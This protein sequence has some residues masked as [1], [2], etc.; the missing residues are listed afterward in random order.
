MATQLILRSDPWDWSPALV[1]D[2]FPPAGALPLDPAKLIPLIRLF[3]PFTPAT[4]LV[5]HVDAD[6]DRALGLSQT[7]DQPPALRSFSLCGL[8]VQRWGLLSSIY[9]DPGFRTHAPLS[10]WTAH[11]RAHN[12]IAA[13]EE[14]YSIPIEPRH[15]RADSR[16][17]HGEHSLPR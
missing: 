12:S 3:D 7:A 8:H 10:I 2:A 6:C 5:G 13:A 14:V 4:W 11:A 17:F 16:A 9:L 15:V 1:R